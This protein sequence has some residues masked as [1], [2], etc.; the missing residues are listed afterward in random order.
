MLNTPNIYLIGLG[1]I[2]GAY[3]SMAKDQGFDFKII[4]NEVRAERYSRDGFIINNKSYQFEY[5]TQPKEEVDMILIAVKA[6]QLLEAIEEIQPFVSQNTIIISLLNGISSE[7][8][9]AE[10]IKVGHI[11]PGFTVK[12]DGQRKGNI[13]NFTPGGK[14]V[15]GSSTKENKIAN[16]AAEILQQAHVPFEQVNNITHKQ[17][18]KMMTNVG[19]NQTQGLLRVTYAAFE[20]EHAKTIAILA[21][22]EVM[23]IANKLGIGLSEND[24]DDILIMVNNFTP[25]NKTSM[26]QD[27][28]AG[29]LTEVDIFAGEVIRLGQQLGIETPI[30]TLLYHTIRHMEQSQKK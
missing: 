18:W 12:T 26:L 20:K 11:L 8:I 3:A 22:K 27:L 1:G 19:I 13:I 25:E 7:R 9:I 21:M 30:N 28:E 6:N 29:R 5:F 14:I 17:W 15:F 4:C 23:R 2:G 24:I 10:K 16:Q